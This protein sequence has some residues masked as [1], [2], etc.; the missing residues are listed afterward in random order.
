MAKAIIHRRGMAPA[1]EQPSSSSSDSSED[2]QSDIKTDKR[3]ARI[4]ESKSETSDRRNAVEI[5]N[6]KIEVSESNNRQL[7]REKATAKRLADMNE[8]VILNNSKADFSSSEYTSEEDSDSDGPVNSV[9]VRPVFVPKKSRET[10][11]QK[12]RQEQEL[13]EKHLKESELAAI[14]KKEAEELLL[15]VLRREAEA[16]ET[17]DLEFEVDDTD[18]LNEIEEF[19]AWK[20]RE[21][22]RIKRDSEERES[23]LVDE[24]DIERRRQ[25]SDIQIEAENT[26]DGK[27][28]VEKAKAKFLQKY[29]HKGAFYVDDAVIGEA[30][31]KT[32]ALAPTLEDHGD[33]S[34]LPS[35]L[36]VKNFGKRGRTKYTHLV[37]QDTTGVMNINVVGLRMGQA[38]K[39]YS[40]NTQKD[41]RTD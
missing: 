36:Q 40:R 8:Q 38:R 25:M 31:K 15:D 26:V 5:K 13:L 32:D 4:T 16:N 7:L 37:D 6:R 3:L 11:A 19:N 21:L 27:L 10:I 18:G 24:A 1:K 35:I 34:A 29:Y 33:K 17:K 22:L 14:K 23:R 20:L 12:D 2:E 9:M 39:L 41:G 30:V 28:G